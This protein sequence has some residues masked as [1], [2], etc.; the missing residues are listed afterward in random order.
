MALR[1]NDGIRPGNRLGARKED[2]TTVYNCGHC[3][4]LVV[5]KSSAAV[6]C[7]TCGRRMRR[8]VPLKKADDMESVFPVR[9]TTGGRKVWTTFH[10]LRGAWKMA[11]QIYRDGSY[12]CLSFGEEDLPIVDDSEDTAV[13]YAVTR[14]GTLLQGEVK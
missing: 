10:P 7:P 6:F 5:R 11:V 1:K 8:L 4:T 12:R 9:T 2:Q 14:K 13:F 3:G